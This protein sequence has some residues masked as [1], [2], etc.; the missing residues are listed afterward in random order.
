MSKVDPELGDAP[1]GHRLFA[2]GTCCKHCTVCLDCDR[3]QKF[4]SEPCRVEGRKATVRAAARRYQNTH[5]GRG[6]H[7]ERQRRYRSR[8]RAGERAPDRSTPVTHHPAPKRTSEPEAKL[9]SAA[10]KSAVRYHHPPC[11]TC[12]MPSNGWV[13][14][15][16]SSSRHDAQW[17]RERLGHRRT[18]SRARPN[19]RISAHLGHR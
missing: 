17:M 13:L 11:V 8:K 14:I 6:K 18:R 7:A 3:G 4:C 16:K 10:V 12:K 2:C 19:H 1:L 5:V 15:P 9:D